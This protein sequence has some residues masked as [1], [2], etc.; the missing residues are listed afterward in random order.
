MRALAAIAF[1]VLACC[2]CQREQVPITRP[3]DQWVP[4]QFA[5]IQ[6]VYLGEVANSGL[7]LPAVSPDGRQIAYLRCDSGG[8]VELDA[9][10]DGKGLEAV[11]LRLRRFADGD[12]AAV[13]CPA[14]AAWPSWSARRLATRWRPGIPRSS[15]CSRRTACGSS[16][17]ASSRSSGKGRPPLWPRSAT[18][19]RSARSRSNGAR[20]AATRPA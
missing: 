20:S 10:F 6:E 2:S 12:E 15:S 16:R 13:V 8:P 9:L 3:D 19:R 5:H 17:P 1:C 7:Q 11:S 4:G 18:S 14:G